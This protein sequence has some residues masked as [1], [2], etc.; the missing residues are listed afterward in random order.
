M[1]RYMSM[2]KVIVAVC[3]IAIFIFGAAS[4][5][6][7]PIASVSKF[8]QEILNKLGIVHVQ[9]TFPE[10]IDSSR[11]QFSLQNTPSL[12]GVF[13]LAPVDSYNFFALD[14]FSGKL[15]AFSLV[16]DFFEKRYLGNVYDQLGFFSKSEASLAGQKI[17]NAGNK[18]NSNSTIYATAFDIDYAFGR[19]YLS[20]TLPSQ[21]QT[22]TSLSLYSFTAPLSNRN[23]LHDTKLHF[24][25]PCVL[26]KKNPTMWAGRI[27]HSPTN[28]YLSVGEQRYDPSGF[29]KV[30]KISISE[31]AKT[32]SPFGKVLEFE[33]GGISYT[34]FSSGHRNAQG[35]YFSKDD[36][37]LVE[38]EH[39]P[40][41]GDEVNIL[42]KG[43]NYGWP[44][45]TF[46]KPY[47]LSDTGNKS[48]LSR[49]VNPATTIDR[50]LSEFGAISGSQPSAHLP[51]MS[52]FPGVGAANITKVQKSSGFADWHVN[53]LLSLMG[54]NSMHRLILSGNSVVHDERI[55]LGIRVR[56]F[57]I[58]DLG[59][60]IL[61]S[62]EGRLLIYK[63]T[64]SEFP[65]IK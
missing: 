29:P 48:D 46:G 40:F 58:N 22:C 15:Y 61:S 64:S 51:I 65:N 35:L 37:R 21:N 55:S 54:E 10:I 30:D 34:I 59:Y 11:Y 45:G 3:M 50:A 56:D 53:I 32:N 44:F 12:D 43:D 6:A 25:S 62:D 7:F 27:T 31:I 63:T 5:L 33:P 41:G 39:G 23:I 20:V 19:I 24:T 52:W 49:S 60:V 36:G 1:S 4:V 8:K 18:K 57:I 17:D 47:P 9:V 38:S 26:D 14:R 28:L 2:R 42:K 16:S 13:Q